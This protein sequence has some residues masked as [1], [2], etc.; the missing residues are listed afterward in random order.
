MSEYDDQ[1]DDYMTDR[2]IADCIKCGGGGQYDD[3]T[4]C[5]FC[6]GTGKEPI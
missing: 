3:C 2:E 1:D 5:P 4:P 6:D